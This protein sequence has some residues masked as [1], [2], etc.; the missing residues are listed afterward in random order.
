MLL[1]TQI[2]SSFHRYFY[3]F[4]ENGENN[5]YVSSVFV[6]FN[7]S[8]HKIN[9]RNDGGGWQTYTAPFG[10]T[11]EGIHLFEWYCDDNMSNVGSVEIKIDRT[12]P[13]VR[14]N[15]TYEGNRWVGY[16]LIFYPVAFDSMSG[17]NR[18]ELYFNGE[19]Y[20]ISFEPGPY[21]K[22]IYSLNYEGVYNV[23]GFIL[24]P[25]ITVNYVKFYCLL[26]TISA[27]H[28][29]LYSWEAKVY[30]YDNARNWDYTT[31]VPPWLPATIVPGPYLFKG[32]I[33]PNNYTGRMGL[34]FIDATFNDNWGNAQ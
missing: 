25:R 29:S 34:F 12:K 28:K 20:E 8:F 11:T 22:F 16:T 1:L 4:Q 10:L 27:G 33:L 31:L 24:N 9:Y 19:L 3:N 17:M 18:V 5:W 32:V 26:V 15:F 6:G 7:G 2:L 23:R 21:Y 13:R 30:A 14:M